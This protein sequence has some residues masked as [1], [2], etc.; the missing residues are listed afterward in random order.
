MS[1]RDKGGTCC[2][3]ASAH[4]RVHVPQCKPWNINNDASQAK[5]LYGFQRNQLCGGSKLTINRNLNVGKQQQVQVLQMF[6]DNPNEHTVPN[7]QLNRGVP[8]L[9]QQNCS[10]S[11]ISSD[12]EATPAHMT[13][14]QAL[15]HYKPKLTE[16]EHQEIFSYTK[17]FF[18]GQNA[19]KRAG[20]AGASNN[21]GY[22]DDQGSY[23]IVP[24]DHVAYRYEVFKVIGKGTF[25]QVIQVYDHKKHQQVAL[26]MVRNK[27]DFHRQV[28]EEIRIL[29]H[30][31]KQ[32]KDNKM[33][34][35]HML[36]HFTFRNHM[37]ITFE[38]LSMSLYEFIKSYPRYC[39]VSTL[40]DGSLVLKGGRSCRGTIRGPPGTKEWTTALKGCD[41]ALF[42]EFLKQCLE[43]DPSLRMTPFQALRHPW[44][45]K[46]LI[47]PQIGNNDLKTEVPESSN[48]VTSVDKLPPLSTSTSKGST[49]QAESLLLEMVQRERDQA[50]ARLVELES[51]LQANSTQDSTLFLDFVKRC[52]EL[53]PLQRMT[54]SQAIHHPWLKKCL[55]KPSIEENGPVKDA[56]QSSN[57]VKS[58]NKSHLPSSSVS[59]LSTTLKEPVGS[60]QITNNNLNA[61]K[62]HQVQ[63]Q[64]MFEENTNDCSTV[65]STQ[66]NGLPPVSQ[67]SHPAQRRQQKCALS[68][69]GCSTSFI[70]SDR[71]SKSVP[72]TS[73]QAM[74]LYKPK[75]TLFEHCEIF[76]YTKI[77]F[78]GQK[79]KK[80]SGVAGTS[81]NCGYDDDQGS[82]I[83]VPHDHVGYRYELLKV[84]GKGTFSQVV[85][86]YDHKTNQQVALKM[87]R[88]KKHFH[89]Q[90]EEEI[91]ILQHL[92]KQDKDNNM[93][94]IHMLEHF[95]FRNHVCIT[96]ELLSISLYE[97]IKSNKF[98]G[99]SLLQ[100]RKFA[101][102][103]LQCLDS[104]HKN[105]II[106]CDLKPQNIMIKQQVELL[107]GYP[108]F[109]GED[110]GDQL[111]CIIELLGMPP[112]RLLDVSKRA[113]NFI[114][115]K[116]Y[117]RYCKVTM[118]SDGS[119]VLNGG[120][121]CWGKFR[122]PPGSKEWTTALKGCDDPLFLDFLKQCLE[123]DPSVRMTP[124]QALHHP[125]LKSCLIKAPIGD[126]GPVKEVLESSENVTSVDK[127]PPLCTST[128]KLRTKLAEVSDP[129]ENIQDRSKIRLM[130]VKH[131][132][133]EVFRENHKEKVTSLKTKMK[134]LKETLQE[135]PSSPKDQDDEDGFQS[136]D[137]GSK[138]PGHDEEWHVL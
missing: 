18:V 95:T 108:L 22:D 94:V 91:R 50:Q 86:A 87:V 67:S 72:M 105:H 43:W 107:T 5:L 7:A 52:L 30:L 124:T 24:H 82:Y 116:G 65:L 109:P 16:F 19:K 58:N 119:V 6:E 31:R 129:T 134:H 123:W 113:K 28:A 8:P 34:V 11:S 42:L 98:Q 41:D 75:L 118:L 63:V 61:E 29:Q 126:N 54:P 17:I 132:K 131:R 1:C 15:K 70:S 45:K 25:S 136:K 125:W 71:K 64:Q 114:S 77:F 106:H 23:I 89:Q 133:K 110:E 32:D 49:I 40:P 66:L 130:E 76:S 38:L 68:Q 80:R 100:V 92:R 44:L 115:P 55:L 27:K 12:C 74:K 37:C 56:P 39:K 93:N 57:A 111:A 9:S 97:F 104:L 14:A 33:N 4:E 36:E 88:N 21:C 138:H 2:M 59:K 84:I 137:D 96:F 90:A 79:A 128:T 13:P 135:K 103:I 35:I 20:I 112:E 47:K 83:I 3:S 62:Q 73:A 120:R 53:D 117:P 121:S 127:L 60:K 101:H 26:K 69:Q 85:Q 51:F 102:P 10:T 81:N 122:G 46:C 99:S 78:V 48:N